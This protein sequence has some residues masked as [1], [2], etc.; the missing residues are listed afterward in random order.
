MDKS[1]EETQ[2]EEVVVCH[3]A[4]EAGLSCYRRLIVILLIVFSC[5]WLE[6]EEGKN[7]VINFLFLAV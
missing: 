4:A 5:D 6:R 3:R 7:F 1:G 2:F